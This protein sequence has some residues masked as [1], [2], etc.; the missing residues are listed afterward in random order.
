L[1]CGN[2]VTDGSISGKIKL[3]YRVEQP[4]V[5]REPVELSSPYQ[6]GDR[7]IWIEGK[8]DNLPPAGYVKVCDTWVSYQCY[9]EIRYDGPELFDV[10]KSE[11][12]LNPGELIS[13]EII[14]KQPLLDGSGDDIDEGIACGVHTVLSSVDP[15]CISRASLDYYPV[16]TRVSMGY[17]AGSS[18]DY[19]YLFNLAMLEAYR[20]RMTSCNSGTERDVAYSLIQYYTDEVNR[21]ERMAGTQ[22]EVRVVLDYWKPRSKEYYGGD[23]R[24][25]SRRYIAGGEAVCC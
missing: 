19:N 13:E 15:H 21:S 25:S 18:S 10:T 16:G 17:A 24:T 6:P 22:A 12:W 2:L 5:L 3:E 7:T 14:S 11:A 1:S 4:P 20:T 8:I 23:N 9:A